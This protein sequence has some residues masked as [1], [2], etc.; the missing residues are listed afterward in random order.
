M[1]S[2]DLVESDSGLC[3]SICPETSPF[4]PTRG[5][6]ACSALTPAVIYYRSNTN[7]SSL[8]R[9]AVALSSVYMDL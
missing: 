6:A 3:P 5:S 1:Q 4:A 2:R 7:R 9:P 8:T